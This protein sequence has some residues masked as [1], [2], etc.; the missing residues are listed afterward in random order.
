METDRETQVFKQ[1]EIVNSRDV[2]TD[3][4]LKSE[5]KQSQVFGIW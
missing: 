4:H 1:P 3:W 2:C 5:H